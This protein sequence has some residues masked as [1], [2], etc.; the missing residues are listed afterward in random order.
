MRPDTSL[1]AGTTWLCGFLPDGGRAISL[2]GAVLVA[3]AAEPY[4][5]GPGQVYYDPST[6][7]PFKMIYLVRNASGTGKR[8]DLAVSDDGKAWERKGQI[9]ATSEV[10]EAAGFTPSGVTRANDGTWALFYHAYTTL[11]QGPA[12][13]ATAPGSEGPFGNKFVIL[14]PTTAKCT[15]S[16]VL[17]A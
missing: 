17:H 10:Y 9:L 13:V 14:E 8:M 15:L 3:N 11:A 6:P 2:Y 12:V 1:D 5:I 16:Q 7:K 4:G